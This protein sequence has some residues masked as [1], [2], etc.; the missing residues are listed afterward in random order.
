MR[1]RWSEPFAGRLLPLPAFIRSGGRASWDEILQGLALTGHFL[2]RQIL[3]GRLEAI[4]ETRHR[5]ADRLSR[6]ASL[7]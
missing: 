4:G 6:A 5:L 2:D 7:R 3:T 1:S